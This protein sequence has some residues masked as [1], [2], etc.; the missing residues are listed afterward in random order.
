MTD[1][2][3]LKRIIENHPEI[4]PALLTAWQELKERKRPRPTIPKEDC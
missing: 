2:E 1:R 3:E 4:L